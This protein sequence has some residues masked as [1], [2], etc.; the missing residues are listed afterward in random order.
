MG[1][2]I[3]LYFDESLNASS[4]ESIL[5]KF[6]RHGLTPS[7]TFDLVRRTADGSFCFALSVY[8]KRDNP[9]IGCYKAELRFSWATE[10]DIY[11]ESLDFLFDLSKKMNFEIFD[12]QHNVC[13]DDTN[14]KLASLIFKG[15][16]SVVTGMLGTANDN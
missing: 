2:Y 8:D 14:I 11:Q 5:N 16:Q 7:H 1:Y 9:K 3:D 6:C 13:F 10:S 12:G 15:T 4:K